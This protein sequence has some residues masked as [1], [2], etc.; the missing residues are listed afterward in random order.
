VQL[1]VSDTG[2]GMHQEVRERAF[3]PFFTT[4]PKGSGTGLG[5]ATTYGI[6]KQNGGHIQLYSEPGEGTVAS[7][8]LPAAA[9]TGIPAAPPEPVTP[10]A[11]SGQRV[12]LVEDEENVR[13]VTERILASGGYAVVCAAGPG[14][15]LK[16]ASRAR[17]D[18]V[19]TDVVMPGMPGSQMVRRLRQEA[20]DLAVVFMSGYTDRPSAL[21]E[22]AAFI[23]KPFSSRDLLELIGGELRRSAHR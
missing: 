8:F 3:E 16:L 21:P 14:E 11:G 6:V 1:V 9:E 20:P 17:F 10:P 4:K 5:L 13:A 18:L 22:D 12:L 15:A 19:L 23:S 2:T 7:V